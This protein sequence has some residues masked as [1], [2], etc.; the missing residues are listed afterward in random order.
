MSITTTQTGYVVLA[1]SLLLG[2]RGEHVEILERVIEIPS[3]DGCDEAFSFGREGDR[4]SGFPPEG[5]VRERS[6]CCRDEAFCE[7]GVLFVLEGLCD[8]CMPCADDFGCEPLNW[9]VGDMCLPCPP[10]E[11]CLPCPPGLRLWERNGCSTCECVPETQCVFPEDCGDPGLVE[12][13]Q[14]IF[15]VEG[16]EGPDCCANACA[17]LGCAPEPPPEGC[18]R[19]CDVPECPTGL[20]RQVG[21]F[22]TPEGWMCDQLCTDEPGPC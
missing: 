14:G 20:C 8:G 7:T 17:E 4:C 2:C 10:A 5:C 16:C 13:V 15:C 18:V 3:V 1:L 6:E 21:C 12:C 9:C 22:C 11:E 19:G